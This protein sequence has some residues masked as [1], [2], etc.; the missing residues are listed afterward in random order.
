LAFPQIKI[1]L[2]WNLES[3]FE[4]FVAGLAFNVPPIIN[5]KGVPETP[6]EAPPILT[7]F[8]CCAL[9]DPKRPFYIDVH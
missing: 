3:A 1:I 5:I 6:I 2:L 7:H 4:F 9:V 8:F